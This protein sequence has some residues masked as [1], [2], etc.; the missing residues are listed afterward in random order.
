VTPDQARAKAEAN[1]AK[2]AMKAE[3]ARRE[4]KKPA[5][6]RGRRKTDKGPDWSG[7]TSNPHN[8]TD[9]QRRVIDSWG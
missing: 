8:L 3:R 6:N 4:G 2:A 7:V 5:K 9:Q 1:A